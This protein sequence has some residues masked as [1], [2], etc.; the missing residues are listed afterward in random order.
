MFL[1]SGE[2]SLP[3][4]IVKGGAWIAVGVT[5]VVF[6]LDFFIVKGYDWI[7]DERDFAATAGSIYHIVWYTEPRD[8]PA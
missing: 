8:M 5:L 7:W 1:F 6:Q 4:L 3:I 2:T